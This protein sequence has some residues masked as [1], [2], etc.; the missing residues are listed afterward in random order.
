M[1][2][3][4]ILTLIT[5]LFIAEL[6]FS[7]RGRGNRGRSNRG[8]GRRSSGR[9]VHHHAPTRRRAATPRRMRA[10]KVVH[11]HHHGA[12]GTRARAR[13]RTVFHSHA[14]RPLRRGAIR[15]PARRVAR[16]IFR[17]TRAIN[18]ALFGPGPRRVFARPGRRI[19]IRPRIRAFRPRVP[20]TYFDVFHRPCPVE[21]LPPFYVDCPADTMLLNA[22][23]GER[24][25]S[26]ER[27]HAALANGARLNVR[28]AEGKTILHLA[29]EKQRPK[30]VKFLLS[31]SPDFGVLELNAQDIYGETALHIAARS[32]FIGIV[33]RLITAGA[34]AYVL[35]NSESTAAMVADEYGFP[36]HADEIIETAVI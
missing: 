22:L 2:R 27:I 1:E 7:A 16:K 5:F 9:T 17:R 6:G 33:R 18:R 10:P 32:G 21:I 12:R 3:F 30:V 23:N 4:K 26:I 19:V 8:G 14:G 31:L 29:V 34:S 20:F 24:P 36:G 35:D 13:G 11:H 28:D 25:G 15:N